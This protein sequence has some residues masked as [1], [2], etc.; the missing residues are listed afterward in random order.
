MACFR[1]RESVEIFLTAKA[2]PVPRPQERRKGV[3]GCGRRPSSSEG[4]GE[5]VFASVAGSGV[6]VAVLGSG[7]GGGGGTAAGNVVA[8][9]IWSVVVRKREVARRVQSTEDLGDEE[10]EVWRIGRMQAR[11]PSRRP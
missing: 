2:H 9:S 8:V 5:V 3:G 10:V 7:T 1:V 11:H 6:A 4:G